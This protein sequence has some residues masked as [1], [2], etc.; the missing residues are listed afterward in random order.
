M[1]KSDIFSF[2]AHLTH[3]QL[4]AYSQHKLI[5]KDLHDVEKHLVDCSLCNDALNG[6]HQMPDVNMLVV[7]EELRKM[8]R[9]R[10]ISRQPIFTHVSVITLIAIIFLILFLIAIALV[11]IDK[12]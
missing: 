12:K 11:I 6:L 7:T 4:M 1:S 10:K 3:D 8:V 9:K 2:G 5:G